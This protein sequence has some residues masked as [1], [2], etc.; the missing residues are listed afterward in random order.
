MELRTPAALLRACAERLGAA[1][2]GALWEVDALYALYFW[3]FVP[4]RACSSD[5]HCVREKLCRSLLAGAQHKD[6]LPTWF[7][8][9]SS[10]LLRDVEDRVASRATVR[11]EQMEPLATWY[12]I[13][14]VAWCANNRSRVA[15][16]D[17]LLITGAEQYARVTR[18][19]GIQP[20]FI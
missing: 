8:K 20:F 11:H 1:T 15:P 14:A 2:D 16:V 17:E 3:Y 5:L 7:E 13:F 9:A 6:C 18:A 10:Y 12:L 19:S 4:S